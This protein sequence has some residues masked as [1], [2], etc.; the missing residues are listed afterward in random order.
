M[1][2][3]RCCITNDVSCDLHV[4]WGVCTQQTTVQLHVSL[5]SPLLWWCLY[6]KTGRK[7]EEFQIEVLFSCHFTQFFC[8]WHYKCDSLAK[9]WVGVMGRAEL[10]C[11]KVQPLTTSAA[12]VWSEVYTRV[13]HTECYGYDLQVQQQ[14][15][16]T[17]LLNIQTLLF[18]LV[19]SPSTELWPW[20]TV[21][22]FTD[23]W[24]WTRVSARALK[25]VT[26][27]RSSTPARKTE[28][29]ATR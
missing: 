4:A 27:T 5:H 22:P 28:G 29:A 1:S 10:D 13:I 14:K 24:A 7:V 16:T 19:L 12:N 23:S 15:W 11:R 8:E 3:D 17:A 6:L 9:S 2:T 18:N 21:C 26:L 25:M 20:A